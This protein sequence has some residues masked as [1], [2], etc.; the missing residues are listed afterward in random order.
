MSSRAPTTTMAIF[1]FNSDETVHDSNAT[2]PELDFH[3]AS[4]IRTRLVSKRLAKSTLVLRQWVRSDFFYSLKDNLSLGAVQT[5]NI[6]E[7]IWVE[8]DFVPT[9]SNSTSSI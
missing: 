8:S 6:L 3:K 2:S 9:H 7:S 4:Q 5:L 1:F